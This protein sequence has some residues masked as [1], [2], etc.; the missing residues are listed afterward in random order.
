M[1]ERSRQRTGWLLVRRYQ[2]ESA[3]FTIYEAARDLVLTQE[4]DATVPCFFVNRSFH[5]SLVGVVALP[6]DA[7][8][9]IDELL[10]RYGEPPE[11]PPP[12]ALDLRR[13]PARRKDSSTDYPESRADSNPPF[14]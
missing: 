9:L 10:D 2:D 4:L 13:R 11:P 5:L 6:D 3:S 8:R 1:T 12:A 14:I 7:F